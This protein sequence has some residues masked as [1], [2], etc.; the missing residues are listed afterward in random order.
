MDLN[1]KLDVPDGFKLTNPIKDID[2]RVE[3]ISRKIDMLSENVDPNN[4][5]YADYVKEI[6]QWDLYRKTLTEEQKILKVR[7]IFLII[8]EVK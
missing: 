7:L 4:Q 3:I 2:S 8:I 6:K 1:Y 5:N